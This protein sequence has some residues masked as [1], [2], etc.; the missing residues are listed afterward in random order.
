MRFDGR[1]NL[2]KPGPE[3]SSLLKRSLASREG[4]AKKLSGIEP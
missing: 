2:T 3:I 4:S 1:E